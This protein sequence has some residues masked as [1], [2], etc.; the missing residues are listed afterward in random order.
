MRYVELRSQL[1]RMISVL[2][3]RDAEINSA[4]HKFTITRMGSYRARFRQLQS[5]SWRRQRG[6]GDFRPGRDPDGR[7]VGEA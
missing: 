1:Y 7:H 3:V 6:K 5:R 2:K 4:L